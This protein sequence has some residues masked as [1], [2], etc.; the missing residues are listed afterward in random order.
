[1]HFRGGTW[2][3]GY[4]F[5]TTEVVI[6]VAFA[7][8]P[9][10]I[11]AAADISALATPLAEVIGGRWEL[12][13]DWPW[14]A[15][16]ARRGER[17]RVLRRPD[18]LEVVHGTRRPVRVELFVATEKLTMG[19]VTLPPGVVTDEFVHPGDCTLVTIEGWAGLT[20]DGRA[21]WIELQERD[22]ARVLAG[23]PY[24]LMNHGDQP[25]VVAFGAAPAWR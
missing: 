3:H 9:P 23:V 10:D 2:H 18:W 22:G 17:I 11:T 15:E 14:N 8:L 6:L 16:A 7:P 19:Q 21:E 25:A 20:W 1:M 24:R 5:G 12:L 13:G 4:N